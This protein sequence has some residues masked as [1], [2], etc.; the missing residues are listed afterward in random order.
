[1]FMTTPGFIV[2][3]LLGLLVFYLYL[4]LAQIPGKLSLIHI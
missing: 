4:E 3:L 2:L 1:M